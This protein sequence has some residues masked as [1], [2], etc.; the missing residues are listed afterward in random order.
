M[1]HEE[2]WRPLVGYEADYAVSNHGRVKRTSSTTRT[3][4]LFVG[5]NTSHGYRSAALTVQ[6]KTKHVYIHRAVAMAFIPNP[7]SLRYVNHIDG[8]KTNNRLEN[9]EWAT[10]RAN[11]IHR[12]RVLGKEIGDSHHNST[13]RSHQIPTIREMA[14]RTRHGVIAAQFGVSREAISAAVRG[15]TWFCV[16]AIA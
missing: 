4:R 1:H 13:L 16:P 9:L 12:S 3:D 10:P 11:L 2:E 14:K 8:D 15:K 5:Q 7:Q 6:C